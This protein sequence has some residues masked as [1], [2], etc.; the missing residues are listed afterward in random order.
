[1]CMRDGQRVWRWS[2][3]VM[4][5]CM[6]AIS[7]VARAESAHPP[8]VPGYYRL[9]DEGK[10]PPAALGEVLLDELNCTACHS[11]GDTSHILAK[12]APNLADAGARLTPQ[13]IKAYLTS[14]HTAKPGA[15]M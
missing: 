15:T 1:M 11:A 8:I 14:P 6:I 13:Y 2:A 12:G 5:L 4:A 7:Q 9:M 10:A 3:G